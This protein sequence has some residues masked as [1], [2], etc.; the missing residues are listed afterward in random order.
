MLCPV[1][2]VG[3]AGTRENLAAAQSSISALLVAVCYM[4]VPSTR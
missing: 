2:D 1:L 3:N 4:I